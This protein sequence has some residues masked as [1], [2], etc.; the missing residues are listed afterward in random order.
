MKKSEKEKLSFTLN[1]RQMKYKF[2]NFSQSEHQSVLHYGSGF[3]RC[4]VR[5]TLFVMMFSNWQ[6]SGWF[7]MLKLAIS[8]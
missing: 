6:L 1:V 7:A 4:D 8:S 5:K 3:V 2:D